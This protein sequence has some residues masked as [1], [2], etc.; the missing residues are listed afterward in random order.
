MHS[1]SDFLIPTA[2]AQ[3]FKDITVGIADLVLRPLI[4]LL[5]LVAT[6][7]FLWGIILYI[8]SGGEEE[9]I[10]EGRK[11]IIWGLIGLFVMVALW[12]IVR[13]LIATLF[14]SGLPGAPAFPDIPG[15]RGP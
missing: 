9:K 4:P 10:R 6:V 2:H 7:V 14:P 1:L 15:L 11:Y 12:G 5:F 8:T 13:A 3:T